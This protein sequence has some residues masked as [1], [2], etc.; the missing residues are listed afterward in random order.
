MA[1]SLWELADLIEDG[2]KHR[3]VIETRDQFL[4][5]CQTETE[6]GTRTI[7]LSNSLSLALVGKFGSPAA[8]EE[9][10]AHF[11]NARTVDPDDGRSAYIRISAIAALLDVP[12]SL[13]RAIAS[14]SAR[15]P[16]VAQHLSA[17]L[18]TG[19]L[20]A[21]QGSATGRTGGPSLLL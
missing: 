4:V 18:R 1:L 9:A 14:L 13:A 12:E 16:T 6:W 20:E 11:P 19:S 8:A 3:D 7:W 17:Q 21:A 10:I 5:R 15:S 2:R